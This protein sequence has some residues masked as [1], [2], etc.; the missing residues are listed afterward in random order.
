MGGIANTIEFF[1]DNGAGIQTTGPQP[2]SNLEGGPLAFS[3]G[4]YAQGGT[5]ASGD[6]V[7]AIFRN[8]TYT[9]IPEPSSILLI[10]SSLLG[11]LAMRRRS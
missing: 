2:W 6:F 4:V 5:N 1:V 10:G 7:N 3:V 9:A 11:L 8:T